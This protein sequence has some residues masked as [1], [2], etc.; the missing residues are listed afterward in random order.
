VWEWVFDFN[1]D[2][3]STDSRAEGGD[4]AKAF[5]GAGAADA[6]DREDYARFMRAA[7]RSSLEARFTTRSLGFRC[8]RDAGAHHAHHTSLPATEPERS[9]SIY[10][11]RTRF[12]DQHGAAARLDVF[13]GAPVVVG[14]VYASCTSVC[15][16]IVETI[17]R[18]EETLDPA[19]RARLRVVLVTLDPARDT[20]AALRALGERHRVDAARWRF[21]TAPEPAVREVAAVLGV[22]YRSTP[23][24]EILHSPVI[25]LLDAQGVIQ[26][27]LTELW[28]PLDDI[29][30]AL[31]AV[32]KP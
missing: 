21:L 7:F 18:L 27:R 1:N 30:R 24:G 8:A 31:H 13:R 22:R 23:D 25:A 32:A 6:R 15:P 20:P 9:A 4:R 26:A 28:G 16:V 3:V 29:T 2:V 5:C 10:A 19:A 12:T 14:M 11:L 17:R